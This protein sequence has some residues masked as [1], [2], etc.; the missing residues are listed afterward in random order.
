MIRKIISLVALVAMLFGAYWFVKG[1]RSTT[2]WAVGTGRI[3]AKSEDIPE[4]DERGVGTKTRSTLGEIAANPTRF[5]GKR[6]TVTGRVRSAGKYA[7]N[8]NI[9]TLV[10]G[11][12][13]ILVIDDKAPPRE[14]WPRTVTG[15]VQVIGP[16]VGGLNRAYL[17]DVKQGVK[18]NPPKWETVSRFFTDKYNQ[19]KSGVQEEVAQR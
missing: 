18:V 7:S 3:Q 16:K 9:Y 11:D 13:R 12:D 19:V 14:Y 17:V 1:W 8:R 6:M 5:Q 10:S 4:R 15:V 2:P